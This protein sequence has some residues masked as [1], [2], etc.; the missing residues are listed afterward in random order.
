MNKERLKTVKEY[1]GEKLQ[2][3][4]DL[5]TSAC[6]S[7]SMLDDYLK[8][9]IKNIN[10]EVL[11]KF[12]GCGSPIPLEL[13]EKTVLD[14]GCGT[15]K[16][17]YTISQLVG[18]NGKVIGIDITNQ[19][20]EIA[21][22]HLGYHTKKFGY[23]KSNIEFKKSLM[24]DLAS[25]AGIADNSIDVV[26]SNCVINLSSDKEKVFGEI[27]RVLKPGGE[28]YFSDV[29]ADKRIPQEIQD[30]KVIVGE[31]L[32]GALYTEDFRR[33]LLKSGFK[34]FRITK[35]EP[36]SL[37]DKRITMKAG[38]INFFSLT[39][40]TFKCDFEDKCEDFGHIAYYKGTIPQCPH[41][42]ELDQSHIF[43]RNYPVKI[44]GNTALMLSKTRFKEH[45]KIVG[46]FSTH[47]GL[48]DCKEKISSGLTA[49]NNIT[50]EGGCC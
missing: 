14:L 47:F 18:E 9:L 31:C 48:F 46:D 12:Y 35:Q 40:R 41:F 22:K 2:N 23:Q 42:F 37:K 49:S 27:H 28:L 50:D 36:I 3:S 21:L 25:T 10:E 32:G 11:S 43:P 17:C 26:I 13:K 39:V 45:F 19:Q 6:C 44:C 4:K 29:F 8:P 1:Y 16:D 34:D 20:L 5:K 15:G 38:M 7:T 30:D 24:E 33:I